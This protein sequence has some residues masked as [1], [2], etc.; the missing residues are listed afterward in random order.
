ML[1]EDDLNN[2]GDRTFR[3]L[4]ERME[5]IGAGRLVVVHCGEDGKVV[6]LALVATGEEAEEIDRYLEG[7]TAEVE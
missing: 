5:E 6:S 4:L 2:F 7:R 1:N 3:Y